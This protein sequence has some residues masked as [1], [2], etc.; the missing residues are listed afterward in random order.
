MT[1][2]AVDMQT[3]IPRLNEVSRI[4]AQ[5]EVQPHVAQHAHAQVVQGQ[6]QR[7]Q[8]QVRQTAQAQQGKVRQEGERRQ[9]G[10]QPQARSGGKEQSRQG[11]EAPAQPGVGN[12]LDVK[13]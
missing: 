3:M 7:A 8:Q 1:V 6:A 13:L 12:R 4:Q 10:Q 5:A 9:G 2:R 11:Q